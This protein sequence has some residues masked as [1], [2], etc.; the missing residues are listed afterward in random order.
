MRTLITGILGY[1]SQNKQLLFLV[2][3]SHNTH[4]RRSLGHCRCS[5]PWWVKRVMDRGKGLGKRIRVG[6]EGA[7][8][9]GFGEF[10]SVKFTK[11]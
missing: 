8:E 1:L 6:G 9:F 7:V 3:K 4:R 5:P 2:S 11:L 10:I